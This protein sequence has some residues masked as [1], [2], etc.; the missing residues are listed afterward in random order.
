MSTIDPVD[1]NPFRRP[2][3]GASAGANPVPNTPAHSAD[4]VSGTGRIIG[5]GHLSCDQLAQAN[6]TAA[7]TENVGAH[8]LSTL[9]M[10][11]EQLIG[12][13]DTLAQQRSDLARGGQLV[14]Q[15]LRRAATNKM[16][17]RLIIVLLIAAIILVLVAKFWPRGHHHNN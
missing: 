16:V 6:A 15:M 8:I 13:S 3:G 2:S 14:G 17:L 10:Q 7:Q 4:A 12:A 5:S 9:G 11:R 1:D